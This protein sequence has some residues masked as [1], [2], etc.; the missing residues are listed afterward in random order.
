V[1]IDRTLLGGLAVRFGLAFV[2]VLTGAR[3]AVA[4]ESPDR[5]PEKRR[6]VVVSP[7]VAEKLILANERLEKDNVDA[8]LEIIDDVAK[9]RRLEAPDRAQLH[10]FRGY[11]FVSKSRTEDAAKEFEAALAEKAMDEASEQGM[12]YSLAQIYAQ[13][14]RYDRALELMDSWFAAAEK[15]KPDAFYLK[16]MILVQHEDFEG[17]LEPAKTAIAMSPEPRESWLQLM[18]AIQ[19]QLQDF[20]GLTETLRRLIALSPRTKRYWVQLA[21]VENFTGREAEALA[22]MQLAY[23]AG[24]LTEDKEIRQLARLL[25]AGE[26]PFQCAAVLERAMSAG[27]VTAD[28]EAYRQ[29]ANCYIAA[30]ESD[31]AI[32]PLAKAGELASDGEVLILL[33][34]MH[35]QK[36]RYEPALEAL[37]HALA[38]AKPEQRGSVQ[39]LLGVAELGAERLDRAEEAFVAAKSDE[40]VRS[41]AESYLKYLDEQRARRVQ[42]TTDVSAG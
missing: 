2:F 8:A 23:E 5:E 12:I 35:L 14:D 31:K 9:S 18:A 7:Q 21:T 38:K 16:A 32:E 24:L 6:D 19:F 11:I 42:R 26:L 41:A 20:P 15:P 33:A 29:L 36:D 40:K 1:Q 25:Y 37:T 17:A 13:L 39:L 34:Q 3:F 30:R 10:R 22:T 27:V 28:G 4:A